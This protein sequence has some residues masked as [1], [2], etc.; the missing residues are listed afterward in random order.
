MSIRSIIKRLVPKSFRRIYNV[1]RCRISMILSRIAYTF[2]GHDTQDCKSIPIVINNF[3][4]LDYLTQLIGS[5]EKRGYHN[6]YIIDN[7]ST[8][9]P[10]LEYYKNCPY[11]VFML[12]R[13]VGFK[14]IWETGIYKQFRKSWYV[15]TD[16]DLLI[17]ENCPDDFMEKFMNILKKYKNAQKAGFG[18]RIDNLP[19]HFKNKELV[20]EHERSFW[21]KETDPGVYEASI[22]T[23]FA[24]YRPFCGGA[25]DDYM[26]N[27]RTGFPYVMHHLP[28]YVDSAAMTDEELY[29]VNNI[30]QSTHW[31]QQSK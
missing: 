17:D 21:E 13:N 18:L 8:Y 5:L 31:S 9:P 12:G 24:L 7:D 26:E 14:A 1:V 29:Y 20:L 16:S 10:L 3:N 4:R 28:W 27:Y 6:I 11:K 23:T 30:K 2:L 25:A 22:D 15:Y 19:D